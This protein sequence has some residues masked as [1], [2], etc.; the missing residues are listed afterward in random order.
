M[1]AFYIFGITE[2]QDMLPVIIETA[3]RERC[4]VSMFDCVYGK[5]QFENYDP[6]ELIDFVK[7]VLQVNNVDNIDVNFYGPNGTVEHS[8]D[9]GFK[10]PDT[11]VIQSLRHKYPIWYPTADQSNIVLLAWNTDSFQALKKS[12]NYYEPSLVVLKSKEHEEFYGKLNKPD[13]QFENY[14]EIRRTALNFEPFLMTAPDLSKIKKRTCLI[15][16]TWIIPGGAA[17]SNRT[18]DEIACNVLPQSTADL[19]TTAALTDKI[20]ALLRSH[21]FYVIWKKR[22]KGQP[23]KGAGKRRWQSPLEATKLKPDFIIDRDLNFPTSLISVGNKVDLALVINWSNAYFDMLSVNPN[24][25]MFD[26][27]DDHDNIIKNLKSILTNTPESKHDTSG[28][29]EKDLTLER[30]VGRITSL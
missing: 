7:K 3:K 11:V 15:S 30:L 14:G 27:A 18:F 25:F 22:E 12:V 21:G 4:W 24:T 1:I 23:P 9:Y 20:F 10:K 28:S 16:E 17:H 26:A 8:K 6:E 29:T 13:M 2:F 5:R 19:K